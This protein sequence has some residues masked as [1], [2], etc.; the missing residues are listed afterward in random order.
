MSRSGVSRWTQKERTA[1]ASGYAAV[2]LVTM[3]LECLNGQLIHIID[4]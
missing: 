1:V 2:T 3:S 4:K